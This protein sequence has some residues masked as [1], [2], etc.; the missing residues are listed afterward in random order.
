MEKR[1]SLTHHGFSF[2]VQ[3]RRMPNWTTGFGVFPITVGQLFICLQ[4]VQWTTPTILHEEST[5]PTRVQIIDT[6]SKG[7]TPPWVSTPT[8]VNGKRF[9]TFPGHTS[10]H[11]GRSNLESDH[12][13]T[14]ADGS[15]HLEWNN[16]ERTHRT[17]FMERIINNVILCTWPRIYK[18]YHYRWKRVNGRRSISYFNNR[19]CSCTNSWRK[20]RIRSFRIM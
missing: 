19:N 12:R 16:L 4:E 7:R 17:T 10:C 9:G 20:W 15:S 1:R 2:H 18:C 3:V 5:E 6:D 13:F 8:K 11:Q 14:R